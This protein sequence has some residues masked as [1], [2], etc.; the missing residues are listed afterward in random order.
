MITPPS[1]QDEFASSHCVVECRVVGDQTVLAVRGELDLA[2]EGLLVSAA[3]A[4]EGHV[5]VDLRDTDF[6]D[7]AGIRAIVRSAEACSRRGRRLRIVHPRPFQRKLLAQLDL[8]GLL[9]EQRLEPSKE[10][11]SLS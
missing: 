10:S 5:T 6:L 9:A 8:T 4:A 11:E 1:P 2:S 3:A 7:G